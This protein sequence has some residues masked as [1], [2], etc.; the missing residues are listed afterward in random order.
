MRALSSHAA[1]IALGF[2]ALG[3]AALKL[4][5]GTDWTSLA[6]FAAALIVTELVE[7]ADTIRTREPSDFEP[8]RVASALH[9]AAA[10]V[11]GPWSAA[12]LA[13]ASAFGVRRLR[14]RSLGT[15]SFEAATVTLAT[16]AGG[17]AV[18][19]VGGHTRR[20]ELLRAPRPALAGAPV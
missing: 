6:L 2:A 18:L 11:L 12:L 19:A 5:G 20:I 14:D 7:D 1:V 17:Y 4:L 13:G 16:L 10:I 9:I 15:V 3:V 8:F